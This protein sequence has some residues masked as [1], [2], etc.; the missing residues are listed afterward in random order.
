[1]RI[2]LTLA[3]AAVV[4]SLFARWRV[5]GGMIVGAMLGAAAFSLATGGAEIELPRPMVG[6]AYV[7][8]GTLIGAG[9]TRETL[10]QLR[11]VAVPAVLS[12]ALIIACG[13]GI[14]LVLRWLGLAPEGVILATS[15]GALSATT[16]V[17]TEQG[18][19]VP[20][21][22]FHLVRV[23][24]VLASLPLLLRLSGGG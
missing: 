21:A 9:I 12:A 6:G 13:L 7:V 1:M 2:V 8:V 16:A 10:G 19:G 20:V 18:T 14:A 23:V 22:V 24:L 15:P 11:H 4:A 5:P 3:A 17:A